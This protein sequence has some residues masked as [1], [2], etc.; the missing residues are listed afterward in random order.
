M[1]RNIV[2]NCPFCYP[3]VEETLKT[4]RDKGYKL[5]VCTNKPIAP[6]KTVLDAV[7]LTGYF[8][9]ILG[10]DSLPVRKPDAAPLH[11]A[12]ENLGDRSRR[13]YV[14]DSEVDCQT[15]RAA[16]V[17]FAIF[18]EGYRKTPIENLPHDFAFS[19]FAALP[20]FVENGLR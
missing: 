15:A 20:A 5:G 1:E 10:G 3:N 13:L 4:F 7:N 19:D 16:K 17:P 11:K 14:G 9:T 6:T 2:E 18:T 12:F 8:D